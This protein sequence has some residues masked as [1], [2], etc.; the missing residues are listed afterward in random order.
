[1]KLLT[2]EQL[3]EMQAEYY[4]RGYRDASDE[5]YNAGW[6]VGTQEK[7]DDFKRICRSIFKELNELQR[8]TWDQ[9]R[10]KRIKEMIDD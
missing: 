2:D 6:T 4:S 7:T 3:K 10:I 9:D 1:M 5:Y 8:N